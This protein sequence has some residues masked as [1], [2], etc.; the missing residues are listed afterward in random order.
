MNALFYCI[1]SST[2]NGLSHTRQAVFFI[3]NRQFMVRLATT[4]DLG[5]ILKLQEKYHVDN[6]SEAE[7]LEKGFV[8]TRFTTAQLT[9]LIEQKGA[10]IAVTETE[11]LMG[12]ALSGT[13]E[14]FSQWAI[15]PFMLTRLPDIRYQNVELTTQNSCQYGPVCIDGAY[16]GKDVLKQLFDAV[17]THYEARFPFICTFINAKNERSAKAHTTKLPL[18]IIDTFGFNN[19]TYYTLACPSNELKIQN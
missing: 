14:F 5:N 3:D 10:F 4:D 16:R 17:L 7:K 1:F 2:K 9:E 13:W 18:E 19:N 8:T 11:E 15:F 12:Y 6:L